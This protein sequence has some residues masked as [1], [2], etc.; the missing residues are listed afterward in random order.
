MLGRTGKL[1]AITKHCIRFHGV[2]QP[3]TFYFYAILQ[4]S[5]VAVFETPSR[6]FFVVRECELSV[7]FDLYRPMSSN[8]TSRVII[9]MLRPSGCI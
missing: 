6:E 4:F 1:T 9:N 7:R 3:A 5:E 8:G 2:D